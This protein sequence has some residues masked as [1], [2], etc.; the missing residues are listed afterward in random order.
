MPKFYEIKGRVAISGNPMTDNKL[1]STF[2]AEY[3]AL[4]AKFTDA[5]GALDM[6]IVT[7]KEKTAPITQATTLAPEPVVDLEKVALAEAAGRHK[8]QAAE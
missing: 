2:Q 6:R 1:L 8:R 4:S 7:E 3:D 5:G